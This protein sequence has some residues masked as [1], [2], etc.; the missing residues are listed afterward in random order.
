MFCPNCGKEL[1]EDITICKFCGLDLKAPKKTSPKK[2]NKFPTSFKDFIL[3]GGRFIVEI[4]TAIGIGF[5]LLVMVLF[6]LAIFGAL[7]PDENGYLELVR[8]IPMWYILSFV[9]PLIILFFVI[10]TKYIMYLL[11]DIRDSLKILADKA[12]KDDN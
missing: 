5:A 4:D 10:I 1:E 6:W 11:I 3:K 7:I 2:D 12:Q 9:I 8:E